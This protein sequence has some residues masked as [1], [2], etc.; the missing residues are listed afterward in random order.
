MLPQPATKQFFPRGRQW[1]DLV[2]GN[3]LEEV[4]LVPVSEFQARA[5]AWQ[6]AWFRFL[7]CLAVDFA[8]SS[9]DPLPD[10][11]AQVTRAFMAWMDRGYS[12]SQVARQ[13]L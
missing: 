5:S 11:P 9:P 2:N 12:A 6:W 13:G 7:A 1:S 8:P 4:A 10:E 3:P